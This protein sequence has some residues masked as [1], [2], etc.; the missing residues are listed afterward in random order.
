MNN[1][2]KG[3]EDALVNFCMTGKL[4]FT[5]FANSIIKDLIR[6]AIQQSIMKWATTLMNFIP[7]MGAPSAALSAD[8]SATIAANPGIF[9]TGGA[10]DTGGVRKFATGDVFDSPTMFGFGG[11]KLGVMGEA[12]PEAIM[13]LKRGADGKL[14]I[15][16]GGGGSVNNVTVNMNVDGGSS[17]VTSSSGHAAQLGQA[18][19]RAVQAEIV[20]QRRPGGLL[21][22]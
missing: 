18:I 2:F 6:I 15:A 22:A 21:A 3:A 16:G 10:F 17:Q 19:S 14:G 7:G 5:D 4:N 1:A 13:P 8:A 20:K 9:A 11:N 12:G